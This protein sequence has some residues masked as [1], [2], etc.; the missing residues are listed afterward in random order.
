VRWS[1]QRDVS[2]RFQYREQ[3]MR[4]F[5]DGMVTW[6]IRTQQYDGTIL[7]QWY[8]FFLLTTELDDERLM[9]LRLERLLCWRECPER[10]SSYQHMLPVLILARS[11]RQRDHW[12][13]AVEST[14]LKLRLE[15][16]VG[17]AAC[18][19]IPESAYAN[20]W[21]L[22]WRT[23]ATDESCHLQDL[24]KPMPRA[25]FPPSLCLEESEEEGRD[26][27]RTLSSRL[28]PLEHPLVSVASLWETLPIAQYT[29]RRKI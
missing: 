7:D 6:C 17:A 28:Y 20:P 21:L 18:L 23:L 13:R 10:W 24:L 16:L 22:N 8:G 19:P 2:H 26:Y 3:V 14:A 1:G 5:A 11:Q 4:F 9:R 29:S 25:T 27:P 15:P 12:Q